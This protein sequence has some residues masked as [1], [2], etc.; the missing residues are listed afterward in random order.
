MFPDHIIPSSI[1]HYLESSRKKV[2]FSYYTI[3]TACIFI[4]S[5]W[6]KPETSVTNST[7]VV[8]ELFQS[9]SW[10]VCVIYSWP[11]QLDHKYA[12]VWLHEISLSGLTQSSASRHSQDMHDHQHLFSW[13][14][15][16]LLTHRLSASSHVLSRVGKLSQHHP[17][18]QAWV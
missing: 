8:C 17:A 10:C 15:D 7:R 9:Q 5:W 11:L 3:S 16:V 13:F 2:V 4:L 12:W 1:I 18:Q 6:S 14:E